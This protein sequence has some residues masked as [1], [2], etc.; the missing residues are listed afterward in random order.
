MTLTI[1]S[2]TAENNRLNKSDYLTAILTLN[3]C[4]L[5]E[6]VSILTPVFTVTNAPALLTAGNYVYCAEYGRYYFI[7]DKEILSGNR[8][9]LNCEIDVLH[10]Y[11]EQITALKVTAERSSNKYNQY[12]TDNSQICR[13]DTMVQIKKIGNS[14]FS[15]GSLQADSSKCFVLALGKG[16]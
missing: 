8:I 5:V 7:R 12:V 6:N 14:P 4:E 15:P 11:H 16:A 1:Y 2:S 9:S 10:T 13:N 3:N